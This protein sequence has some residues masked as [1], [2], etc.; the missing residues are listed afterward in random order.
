MTMESELK[1]IWTK[2]EPQ[3]ASERHASLKRSEAEKDLAELN[4]RRLAAGFAMVGEQLMG[5]AGQ[6]QAM[7]HGQA[8][9]YAPPRTWRDDMEGELMAV[10]R[11]NFE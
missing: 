3:R 9:Y 11:R 5:Y 1:A 10:I 7:H 8:G 4:G 6:L 2:Y